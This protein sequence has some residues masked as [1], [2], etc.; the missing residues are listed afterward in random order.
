MTEAL[1]HLRSSIGRAVSGPSVRT[2]VEIYVIAIIGIAF[3]L[4]LRIALALV[5]EGSASYL[6]FV[7]AILI[8]SALGG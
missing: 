4:A 5:L 8:A 2:R 6:F 7:P 3:G 1:S